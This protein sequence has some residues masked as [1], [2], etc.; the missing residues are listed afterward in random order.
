MGTIWWLRQIGFILMGSLFLAF[1]IH[2]LVN[3]YQLHNPLLFLM[4]FFSSNF[5]ILISVTLLIIF[6]RQAIQPP[7]PKIDRD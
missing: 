7:K 5:I 4:F 6:V 1:G 3:A 2:L